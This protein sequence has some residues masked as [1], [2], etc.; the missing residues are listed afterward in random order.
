MSDDM[1]VAPAKALAPHTHQPE[2]AIPPVVQ[3]VL[4]ADSGCA[5]PAPPRAVKLQSVDTLARE[6]KQPDS[7]T[8]SRHV[9]TAEVSTIDDTWEPKEMLLA[10]SSVYARHRICEYKTRKEHRAHQ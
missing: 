2:P 10:E 3:P 8:D 4:P 5:H 9:T 1:P 6:R 7:Y